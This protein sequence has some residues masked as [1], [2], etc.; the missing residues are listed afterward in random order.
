MRATA[1]PLE[2]HT[3]RTQAVTLLRL[4]RILNFVKALVDNGRAIP[5][6]AALPA[7][8][9]PAT[10]DR[11]AVGRILLAAFLRDGTIYGVER[12]GRV[13]AHQTDVALVRVFLEGLKRI[14]LM[15]VKG[16]GE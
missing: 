9:L 6:P 8:K 3:D 1:L 12:D 13:Y 2:H 15:G 5:Q 14:R 16:Q 7:G 11:Q 4:G 10:L